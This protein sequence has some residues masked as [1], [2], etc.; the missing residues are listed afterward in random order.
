ME[1][2]KIKLIPVTG[3]LLIILLYFVSLNFR[4]FFLPEE[5]VFAVNLKALFPALRGT[6]LPKLPAACATLLT[7]GILWFIASKFKILHPGTAAAIYLCFPPVWWVGT[8]ALAAPVLAMLIDLA[9][10]GLFLARRE[11]HIG[12]K[13][14]SFA[15]GLSGAA[16]AA[17]M[18]VNGFFDW[19]AVV[20][21]FMPVLALIGAI[22]L[23][24]LD[25][26]QQAASRLN[27]LGAG[28]AVVLGLILIFLM[29]PSF[30]RMLK[31]DF[32]EDLMVFRSGERI[33]RP[34]LALLIPMLWIYVI[35][36]VKSYVEKLYALLLAVGF[37][38]LT[39][40]PALPWGRLAR[41]PQPEQLKLIFP[42]VVRDKPVYFADASTCGAMNY[43]FG[44]ECRQVG[45][46]PD[47][48]PPAELAAEAETA[49]K[50]SDVVIVS[51]NGELD[52]FLPPGRSSVKSTLY[53]CRFFRFTGDY[54]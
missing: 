28:T 24:K 37:V 1:K 38:M 41:T 51:F 2:D 47:D 22:H 11:K 20:L 49:L 30:A 9:A 45:R 15:V 6:Y 35:F 44:V 43:V 40:P 5:Y 31:V 50:K 25:D 53:K 29:L 48:L 7:G 14:G 26:R 19:S 39:L 27:R 52:A 33:Y 18:A 34:A 42:E 23:E 4:G 36:Q 10:A 8:S 12:W 32:P 17:F 54:K 16:G 3:A 21:A 46:N 13:I